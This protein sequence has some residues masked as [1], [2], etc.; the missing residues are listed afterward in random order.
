MTELERAMKGVVAQVKLVD[1]LKEH[2]QAAQERCAALAER[3]EILEENRLRDLGTIVGLRTKLVAAQGKTA[4][5]YRAVENL[6]ERNKRTMNINRELR[7]ELTE[8]RQYHKE[9]CKQ[10]AEAEGAEHVLSEL[11]EAEQ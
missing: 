4:S 8:V 7:N 6:R 9:A 10:L 5:L 11:N 1:Q 3:C 2:V